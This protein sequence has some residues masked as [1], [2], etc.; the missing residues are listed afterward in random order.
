V[1]GRSDAAQ[2]EAANTDNTCDHT[3]TDARFD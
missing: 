1:V 2:L 3:D